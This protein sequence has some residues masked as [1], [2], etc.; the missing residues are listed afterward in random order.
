VSTLLELAAR[1]E[2]EE[3]GHGLGEDIAIALGYEKIKGYSCR[4][5]TPDRK[6][7]LCGIGPPSYTTSIDA[8]VTLVPEKHAWSVS[9]YCSGFVH[10][11]NGDCISS[12]GGRTPA[13]RLC[14]AALRARAAITEQTDVPAPRGKASP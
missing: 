13:L 4:W 3:P 1:C 5:W 2:R 11:P 7:Q 9:S 14:A 8:A 10:A 12:D 6:T